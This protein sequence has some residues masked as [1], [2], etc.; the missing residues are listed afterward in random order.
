MLKKIHNYF[1]KTK[2][3]KNELNSY[4]FEKI[5]KQANKLFGN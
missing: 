1:T 5:N 3:I 4:Y 2:I